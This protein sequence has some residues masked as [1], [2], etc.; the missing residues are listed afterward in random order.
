MEFPVTYRRKL[1]AQFTKAG[2][3]AI[4]SSTPMVPL[5]IIRI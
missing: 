2:N 3:W 1:P 4:R 5:S